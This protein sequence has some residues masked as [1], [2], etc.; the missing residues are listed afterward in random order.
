MRTALP[1]L[2][3]LAAFAGCLAPHQQT[4]D[5][6]GIDGVAT[7]GPTC[8]A[9][10]EPPDPA[11][12]DK[13]YQGDFAALADGRVVATFASRADGAFRIALVPGGYTIRLADESRALPRCA[14]DGTVLVA[15][16]AW[17]RVDL[18]CDSGIR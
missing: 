2:L 7:I 15:E 11:C 17:T 13:P 5:D 6:S 12:A 16:H 8:P 4:P 1:C 3:F 10:R 18:R 14:S 9:Q